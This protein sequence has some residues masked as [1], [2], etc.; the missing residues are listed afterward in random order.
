MQ[1][2]P[3]VTNVVELSQR[4]IEFETRVR[5]DTNEGY[6][7][8]CIVLLDSWRLRLGCLERLGDDLWMRETDDDYRD[9]GSRSQEAE[10]AHKDTKADK[11]TS[12]S[13][14]R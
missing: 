3:I 12:N 1:G 10:A 9:A 2:T 6:A 14:G 8:T 5:Q 4:M 11:E 13:D 7:C